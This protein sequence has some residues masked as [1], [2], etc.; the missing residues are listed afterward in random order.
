MTPFAGPETSAR[1]VFT[2]QSPATVRTRSTGPGRKRRSHRQEIAQR[3]VGPGVPLE[4]LLGAMRSVPHEC[5]ELAQRRGALGVRDSVEVDARPPPGRP[6]S[7]GD[8]GGW[9]QLICAIGPVLAGLQKVA[10]HAADQRRTGTGRVR[11][12]FAKDSFTNSRPTSAWWPGHE[13][14]V[15]QFVQDGV[16]RGCRI[17]QAVARERT[18]RSSRRVNRAAF[19]MAPALYS[20]RTPGRRNR[21]E[22]RS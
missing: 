3:G 10:R 4:V 14:H 18:I 2:P 11:G 20:G 13:P 12:P 1:S 22:R 6:L 16:C 15:R 19:S 9:R 21:T 5:H 7:A 17:A 8:R